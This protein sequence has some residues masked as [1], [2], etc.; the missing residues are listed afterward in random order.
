MNWYYAH[1]NGGHTT[2]DVQFASEEVAIAFFQGYCGSGLESIHE[3][4]GW[5]I[6]LA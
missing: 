5:L 1:Y 2:R 6:Y 3:I 4:D